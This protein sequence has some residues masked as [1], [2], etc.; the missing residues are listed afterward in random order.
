MEPPLPV[1]PDN[2]IGNSREEQAAQVMTD[3]GASPAQAPTAATGRP[4]KGAKGWKRRAPQ[5]GN[6]VSPT[7]RVFA[8]KFIPFV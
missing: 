6:E 1:P 4:A 7:P 5:A 3:F 8:H 2:D